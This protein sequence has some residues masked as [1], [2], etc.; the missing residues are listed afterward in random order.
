MV[1]LRFNQKQVFRLNQFFDHLILV[2]RLRYYQETYYQL[3]K[4]YN[5]ILRDKLKKL[6]NSKLYICSFLQ[7]GFGSTF[8]LISIYIIFEYSF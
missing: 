8:Y 5:G 6:Q 7:K 4:L 1:N 2:K 3:L